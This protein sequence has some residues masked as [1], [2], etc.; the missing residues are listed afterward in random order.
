MKMKKHALALALAACSLIG[1]A[2]QAATVTITPTPI[3]VLTGDTFSLDIKVS[4]LGTE[5]VSVFDLNVYFNPA[6]LTGVSYTLGAGLGGTWTD[7]SFVD[8]NNFDL[9]AFSNLV[10]P[11]DPATD[12]L[13]AALQ[14]PG[15]FTLATLT[16]DAVGAGVS[17]V[18]F[19]LGSNE[20]DIVGRSAQFISVQFQGACVAVNSPTGGNNVCRTTSIPEPSTYTL[21]ALALAGILVPGALRRRRDKA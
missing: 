15:G 17:F 9:F 3:S 13:L 2:A 7:L 6:M 21:A 19:G 8:V 4:N 18:D 16:F 1:A 14:S 20:R 5:I 10:D 11:A 12:D